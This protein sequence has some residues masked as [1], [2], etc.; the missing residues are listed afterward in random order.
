MLVLPLPILTFFLA[1]IVCVLVWRLDLGHSLARVLFAGLFA[2]IAV[3]ALLVGLRFGYKFEQFA[4]V[5]R[6][7]PLF[8]GPCLYL[9]FAVLSLPAGRVQ[10]AMAV[11]FGVAGLAALLPQL[12]AQYRVGY[13]AVIAL[14]YLFY[15]VALVVL[16]RKGSDHLVHARLEITGKLRRWILVGVALLALML[17]VD[18]AIAFNFATRRRDDAITLISYGSMITIGL[19]IVV[20]VALSTGTKTGARKKRDSATTDADSAKLEQA[21]RDLLTTS[22]LYLDTDLSIERLAKRLHVPV[23]SLSE[24]INQSQGMNVSQYVNGFRLRHA[25]G[26]LEN[27]DLS[28]TK[29][30]E[31]SGFLARSNFYREFQRVYGQSPATYRQGRRPTN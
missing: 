1:A 25:A 24:A 23:R 18:I 30:A 31:Q 3:A 15:S 13:D 20:I 14:S 10:R 2:V 17:I 26:L 9:G 27:S 12:T 6:I 8:I 16:W 7:L 21:A 4:P 28:V 22:R 19:L 11:H 29:I 5:Q